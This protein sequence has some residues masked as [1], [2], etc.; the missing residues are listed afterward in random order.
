MGIK[1]RFFAS[2]IT[3]LL[4][5]S[6]T[7][8]HSQWL[9]RSKR[10]KETSE[11]VVLQSA[12]SVQSAVVT[13]SLNIDIRSD[14]QDTITALTELDV[15][16]PRLR[17]LALLPFRTD[18]MPKKD[19]VEIDSITGD[20]IV[21]P[22]SLIDTLSLVRLI[23]ARRDMKVALSFYQGV[24]YA[25]DSL[26]TL[27]IEVALTALDTR[28][29]HQ[30]IEQWT[31]ANPLNYDLVVGP[32]SPRVF[33]AFTGGIT[34]DTLPILA[35]LM[36]PEEGL[37]GAV[38]F[39]NPSEEQIR[40]ELL[41][42]AMATY[43]GERVFIVADDQHRE[44]AATIKNRFLEAKTVE[45]YK[46]ISITDVQS[47]RDSI[48]DS[49]IPNWTFLET[50][51]PS[52]AASV[53]SILSGIESEPV[54]RMRM[55]T[56]TA[57]SAYY[58]SPVDPTHLSTLRFTFP[59][60][61]GLPSDAFIESFESYYGFVPDIMTARAFD[62]TLD[63]VLRVAT[64]STNDVDRVLLPQTY[65]TSTIDYTTY[66]ENDFVNSQFRL[67]KI[68]NLNYSAVDRSTDPVE[69][70][71]IISEHWFCD[72]LLAK[73]KQWRPE[74]YKLFEIELQKEAE[75]MGDTT[76]ENDQV[77]SCELYLRFKSYQ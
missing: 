75:S 60:T 31:A 48:I 42:Y 1:R 44:A 71:P 20:S 54:K 8:A 16:N 39:G 45:L 15:Q 10:G 58:E 32:L 14:Q 2:I 37:K 24:Q 40:S 7:E 38:F 18:L 65:S 49:I 51:N 74:A 35:P 36:S 53:S 47:F 25:I 19:G 9:K 59:E 76:F 66:S 46:N 70:W 3:L 73:E 4:V 11:N 41:E 77:D 13:D 50:K 52:L 28:L 29:D 33:K 57:S 12:Q 27:G 43:Q 69:T 5:V 17:L 63:F 64:N 68:S 30:Y 56:T 6:T 34:N 21:V 23:D 67:A 62:L 61:F 22:N 72:Y 26:A 55:F